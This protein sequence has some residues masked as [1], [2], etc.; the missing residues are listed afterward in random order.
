MFLSDHLSF[1]IRGCDLVH[2]YES[3]AGLIEAVQASRQRPMNAGGSTIAIATAPH[4]ASLRSWLDAFTTAGRVRPADAVTFLD[5]DATLDLIMAN[6]GQ[7]ETLFVATVGAVVADAARRSTTARAWR[8]GR[9]T[10]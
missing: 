2:F 3:E 5:A 6:N 10:G 8:D 7:D 1:A 9:H 4:L